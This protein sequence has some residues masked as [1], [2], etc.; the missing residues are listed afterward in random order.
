MVNGAPGAWN[1]KT[2]IGKRSGPFGMVADEQ[3]MT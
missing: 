1:W 3:E 2:S